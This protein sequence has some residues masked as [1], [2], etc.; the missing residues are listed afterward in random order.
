MT[1][2]INKLQE[3]FMKMLLKLSTIKVSS[4][5]HDKDGKLVQSQHLSQF[6]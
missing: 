5:S 3:Q 2:V 6:V 4:L 1:N